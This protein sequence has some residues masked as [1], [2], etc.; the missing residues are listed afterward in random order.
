[1]GVSPFRGVARQAE[2]IPE[3][4]RDDAGDAEPQHPER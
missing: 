3:D 4:Q 1:M 2:R